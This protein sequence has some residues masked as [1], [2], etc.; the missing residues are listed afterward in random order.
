VA[1]PGV[2]GARSDLLDATRDLIARVPPGVPKAVGFGISTPAQA[3][4]IIRAGADAAIVGSACVDLIARRELD[5]LEELVRDMK[6]AVVG[7]K[8]KAAVVG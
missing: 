8:R 6:S 3:A 2:T 1:R 5:R 7:T 4:E